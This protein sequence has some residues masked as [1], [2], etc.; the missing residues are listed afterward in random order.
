MLSIESEYTRVQRY[1]ACWKNL[2]DE[3]VLT[4]E[5]LCGPMARPYIYIYIT[6]GKTTDQATMCGSVRAP[7]CDVKMLQMC[8]RKRVK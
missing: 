8:G 3:L 7:G 6:V 2:G 5:S 1:E 4:S